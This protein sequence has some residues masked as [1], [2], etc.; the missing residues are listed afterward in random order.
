MSGGRGR[1]ADA[2]ADASRQESERNDDARAAAGRRARRADVSG[3]RYVWERCV[4][5]C[6]GGGAPP[7]ELQDALR[8]D[9]RVDVAHP[10]GEHPLV[11]G[12]DE[13]VDQRHLADTGG[14]AGAGG[15]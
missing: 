11:H 4:R 6:P 3:G 13:R 15:A 7:A 10:R 9:R 5:A 1:A 8:A 14:Q 12:V 2:A